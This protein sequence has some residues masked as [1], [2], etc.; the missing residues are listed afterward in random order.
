MCQPNK[1][2]S[3]DNPTSGLLESTLPGKL[4]NSM[5]KFESWAS[6]AKEMSLRLPANGYD[7]SIIGPVLG[8]GR[9][10]RVYLPVL[11][12]STGF[13][14]TRPPLLTGRSK[15]CVLPPKYFAELSG[16]YANPI[17]ESSRNHIN[18]QPGL[19]LNVSTTTN[20]R[21]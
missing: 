7:V 14:E 15:H 21:L 18:I 8:V 20:H 19:V 17:L 13:D 4:A 3:S 9:L 6:L 16:L 5:A 11:V 2:L 10:T 1:N 12:G